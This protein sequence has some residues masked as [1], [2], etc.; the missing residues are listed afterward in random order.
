MIYIHICIVLVN[1]MEKANKL[2]LYYSKPIVSFRRKK[3]S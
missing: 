2:F 3:L 1:Y